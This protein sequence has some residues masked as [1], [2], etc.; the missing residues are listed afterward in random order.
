M[1]VEILLSHNLHI[2]LVLGGLFF[3]LATAYHLWMIRA[4][5]LNSK[6]QKKWSILFCFVVLFVLTYTAALYLLSYRFDL[7]QWLFFLFTFALFVAAAFV[8]FVLITVHHMLED[9]RTSLRHI[10][11]LRTK[12]KELVHSIISF[13]K[14]KRKIEFR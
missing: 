1:V 5:T 6:F 2:L 13:V 12:Q 9:L 4:Y 11:I 3:L 7:V 10:K 14:W 8:L